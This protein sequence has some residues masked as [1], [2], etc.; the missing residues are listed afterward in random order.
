[1]KRSLILIVIVCALATRLAHHLQDQKCLELEGALQ[2]LWGVADQRVEIQGSR[3][4]VAANMPA[5]TSSPQEQ[6]NYA[7]L[8]FVAHARGLGDLGEICVN[9]RR[10]GS[11][12]HSAPD[13]IAKNEKFRRNQLQGELQ[14]WLDQTL[15]PGHGLA[16]VD[17]FNGHETAVAIVLDG[18]WPAVES[19]K[20]KIGKLGTALRF[21]QRM[22]VL[23]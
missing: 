8:R 3:L 15:E 2:L 9:G 4:I 21:R 20:A 13:D 14:V 12:V 7:Y 1:M 5:N 10:Q 23:P 11:S 22:L 17:T 6:W 19:Q 18:R 16:L